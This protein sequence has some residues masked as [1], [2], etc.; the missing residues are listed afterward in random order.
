MNIRNEIVGI[1]TEVPCLDGQNCK[2]VFLD[3]ATSTPLFKCVL[4]CIEE[5]SPWYSAVHR[6]TGFKSLLATE[7]F[8]S[9]HEIA[10]KFVGADLSTNTVIFVKNTTEAVNK[11]SARFN[12][13][14]DDIVVT[15]V[16]EHHS[17]DLPWR[18]HAKVIHIDTTDDGHLDLS[19]LKEI[20]KK[21][22]SRIKLVA[23]NGA[24]NITGFINPYHDIAE[25]AHEIGAKIFL[26]A[27]QLAPHR[28]I[29]VLPDDD[30]HHIDFIAYSAHKLY[31]P[32]GIGVL[33]G[34]KKFFEIGAPEMV[35]GGT[36]DIVTLDEVYWNKPPF[37]EEAGSPN[38]IGAIAL[39]RSILKL[40]EI[41]MDNIAEHERQ[42]LEYAYNKLRKL[43]QLIIYGYTNNLNDKVGVIAFNIDGMHHALV[44]SIL[45]YEGGIGVRNGCFCAH[46][47]VKNLLRVNQEDEHKLTEEIKHG[48]KSNLP[49]MVRAS[50]GCYNNEEDI[51]RLVDMLDRIIKKDYKG[52][53]VMNPETGVYSVKGFKLD[54]EQYFPL[55]RKSQI[56]GEQMYPESA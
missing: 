43:S 22:S 21:Y 29:N 2:Y 37:K 20:L 53:Y 28:A 55:H 12:F 23:I 49:G 50:F 35:G 3:N 31:A 7:L 40:Q 45:G 13:S 16:M 19:K 17:N 11:L 32:F 34:P 9:A 8:D 44:A 47:Y 1:N 46:P 5:F 4:K 30:K 26:D 54:V 24:S 39:A 14:P 56:S 33:V 6:G 27:A 48:D 41:G 10:G 36:V 51:E 42:L 18:K 52:E 25:W 15:T 38:V